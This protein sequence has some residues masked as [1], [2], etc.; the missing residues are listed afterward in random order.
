LSAPPTH[1]GFGTTTRVVTGAVA[2]SAPSPIGDPSQV[3]C[4]DAERSPDT[5]LLS[6]DDL[7][8]TR[9]AAQSG[10]Q[11]GERR[12]S[13]RLR[14]EGVLLVHALRRLY[15]SADETRQDLLASRAPDPLSTRRDLA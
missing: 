14:S 8:V 12:A 7:G 2:W 1:D 13:G 11:V 5:Q 6:A 3:T 9:R 10:G 15:E 4:R